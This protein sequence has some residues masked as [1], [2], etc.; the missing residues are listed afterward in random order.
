RKGA[1]S[2]LLRPTS[3][4]S[5]AVSNQLYSS[6]ITRGLNKAIV[7]CK[8]RHLIVI[9][10]RRRLDELQVVATPNCSVAVPAPAPAPAASSAVAVAAPA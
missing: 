8:V 4:E 1:A 7:A 6:P 5:I 9:N 3:P 2:L 10:Q